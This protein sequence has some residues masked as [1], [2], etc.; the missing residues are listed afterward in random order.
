[1]RRSDCILGAGLTITGAVGVSL[2]L[3]GLEV[4]LP[5]SGSHL[6]F[7]AVFDHGHLPLL[8]ASV[9]PAMFLSLSTRLTPLVKLSRGFTQ[10]PL[11]IPLYCLG[12][13]GGFW[14]VVSASESNDTKR[15]ASQGWL[16]AAPV[17]NQPHPETHAWNYWALFDFGKIEWTAVSAG[18]QD[19]LLLVV[20][21]ALTL[22][23]FAPAAAAAMK[24]P[25]WSLSRESFGHALANILAGALGT[26]P[27][28]MVRPALYCVTIL[29]G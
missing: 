22:Y 13:A 17:H 14:L 10:D 6:S 7:R 15:L 25:R 26:V 12:V 3:L 21:G 29:L 1:M 18:K 19:M 16:F 2:F 20:I 23:V 8:A 28:L 11:Y 9:M 27:C 5:P 4:T 24:L